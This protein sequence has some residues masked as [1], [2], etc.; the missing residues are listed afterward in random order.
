[1]ITFKQ[2]ISLNEASIVGSAKYG[3]GH[4]VILKNHDKMTAISS[5]AFVHAGYTPG[6]SIFSILTSTNH[7]SA[8]VTIE[9]GAG[10]DTIVLKDE[11]NRVVVIR[12]VE[13]S[14]NGCFKHFSGNAKS[15]TGAL[16]EV[17][18]LVSVIMFQHA[19]ED[20]HILTEDELIHFLNEHKKYYSP[21]FYNSARKQTLALKTFIGSRKGYTYERQGQNKTKQLYAL[22]RKLSKKANDNWNPA[23]VWMIEANFNMVD[24]LSSETIQELNSK[25]AMAFQNKSVIPISLKQVTKEKATLEIT[26][27]AAQ[28]EQKL[29][30]DTNFN[31]VD[32]SDSFANFIVYTKSGFAV[33]C[34]F[35]ASSTTVDVSLEGRFTGAGYQLG[36]V[37]A[38]QYAIHQFEKYKYIVR[39]GKKSLDAASFQKAKTELKSIFLKF[40]KISNSAKLKDFAH[41]ELLIDSSDELTKNRFSNLISYLYSFLISPGDAFDE[42]IAVCYYSSKKLSSNS[43]VYVVIK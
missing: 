7:Q 27:P 11:H 34:G 14:I 26:D 33:R 25:L 2:F 8:D 15:N 32:L 12:G 43:A 20:N 38:K 13:N 17:K 41:A 5:K 10:K 18:E 36:G 42:N 23:D 4:Q 29:D 21:L 3:D 39:S 30:I 37:D 31:K 16:T 22:A 9:I 1:M 28:L 40:P 24:L 19:I 35:K 6:K